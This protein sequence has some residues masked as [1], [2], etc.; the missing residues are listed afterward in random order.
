MTY[1]FHTDE[2]HNVEWGIDWFSGGNPQLAGITEQERVE[3]ESA[4]SPLIRELWAS[5]RPAT[6]EEYAARQERA[7]E[8]VE[9]FLRG[10]QDVEI[11]NDRWEGFA[12]WVRVNGL[13]WEGEHED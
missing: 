6:E 8:A 5:G 12:L 10:G 9:K 2:G 4:V 3:A 1:E 11:Y 7:E 13:R